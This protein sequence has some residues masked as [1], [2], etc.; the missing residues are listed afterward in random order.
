MAIALTRVDAVLVERDPAQHQGGLSGDLGRRASQQCR[1]FGRPDDDGD[2]T[3]DV[4]VGLSNRLAGLEQLD[5]GRGAPICK[6]RPTPDTAGLAV[7]SGALARP[8]LRKG[9]CAAL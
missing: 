4:A 2:T 6:A 3:L 9:R 1:L 8:G 5:P 7:V